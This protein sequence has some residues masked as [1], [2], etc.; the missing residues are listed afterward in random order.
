MKTLMYELKITLDRIVKQGQQISNNAAIQQQINAQLSAAAG[1]APSANTAAS[2]FASKQQQNPK[3]FRVIQSSKPTYD[4]T[5]AVA[6]ENSMR[7]SCM[8]DTTVVV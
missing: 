8:T 5:M 6:F 3:I 2:M 4:K 1:A 7:V